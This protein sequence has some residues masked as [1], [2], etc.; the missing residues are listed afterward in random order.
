MGFLKIDLLQVIKSSL[1]ITLHT[2]VQQLQRVKEKLLEKCPA[3]ASSKN[4]FL[5]GNARLHTERM[6]QGKILELGWSV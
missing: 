6:T 3:L 2:Y 4:I 1:K 5:H